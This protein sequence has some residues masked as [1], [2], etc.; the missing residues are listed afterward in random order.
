MMQETASKKERSLAVAI[1]DGT[2]LHTCDKLQIST[3]YQLLG[4]KIAAGSV[5]LLLVADVRSMRQSPNVN[6]FAA[7]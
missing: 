5:M 4:A 1:K 3:A 6:K 2:A 7:E